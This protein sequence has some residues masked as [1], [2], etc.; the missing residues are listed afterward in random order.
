LVDAP[1]GVARGRP[2]P[3]IAGPSRDFEGEARAA[4]RKAFCGRLEA[5]PGRS[6]AWQ[7]PGPLGRPMRK[8]SHLWRSELK[9]PYS[10]RYQTWS[11]KPT[12]RT[13]GLGAKSYRGH[14][15]RR[16]TSA[17]EVPSRGPGPAPCR[18]GEHPRPERAA[19]PRRS[20]HGCARRS[21]GRWS[22]LLSSDLPL[23]HP[24]PKS[25]I[26]LVLRVKQERAGLPVQAAAKRPGGGAR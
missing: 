22:A 16:M 25:L 15:R 7:I 3:H 2:T 6:G 20:A 1:T 18:Q 14:P 5:P 9:R 11:S 26:S 23:R 8:L 4:S 21:R 24:A 12:G 19:S 17:C 13:L 10:V